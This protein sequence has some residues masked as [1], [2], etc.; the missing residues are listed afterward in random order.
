MLVE[1][2]KSVAP[3]SLPCVTR[4][5]SLGSVEYD[6]ADGRRKGLAS[7]LP[8][9]LDRLQL[10]GH[11]RRLPTNGRLDQQ[12]YR[13][14]LWRPNPLHSCKLSREEAREVVAFIRGFSSVPAKPSRTPADDFEAR[15]RMLEK[16]LED[17]RRQSRA[18]SSSLPSSPASPAKGS[19]LPPSPPGRL[20]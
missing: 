15:F 7:T 8:L 3:G 9:A 1:H 14:T 2:N 20:E 13:Y 10:S 17:L 6:V 4:L 12:R 18:L 19:Q 11:I 16:E 5:G